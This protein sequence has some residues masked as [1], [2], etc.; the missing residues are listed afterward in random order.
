MESIVKI[1][2]NP[3]VQ[4]LIALLIAWYFYSI[5]Q[6][7]PLPVYATE[8]HQVFADIQ[9]NVPELKLL[10]NDKPISNFY[11]SRVAIWNG[12]NDY[13]DSSRLNSSDPIRIEVPDNIRL[14]NFYISSLSRTDLAVSGERKKVNGKT[15]VA[16]SLDKEEALEANDGFAVTMYF[17]SDNPTDFIVAGRVKGI[18]EGFSLKSWQQEFSRNDLHWF[19]WVIIFFALFATIDALRDSYVAFKANNTRQIANYLPRLI[20][21]PITVFV[22]IYYSIIPHFF[23]MIWLQ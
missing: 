20:G 4:V 23:G 16:F 18:S 7:Q 2:K 22:F 17:T 19:I 8:K 21:G 12:G 6:K 15:V 11:S 3:I 1:I 10:W 5:G 13:I 9:E 14:L